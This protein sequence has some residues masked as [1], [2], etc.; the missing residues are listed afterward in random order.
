[1]Q[2]LLAL[3]IKIR[4]NIIMA[5]DVKVLQ[6]VTG[7]KIKCVERCE[8]TFDEIGD[9]DAIAARSQARGSGRGDHT[10]FSPYGGI[11]LVMRERGLNIDPHTLTPAVGLAVRDTIL[12]VLGISTRLKWVNDVLYGDKKVCGILCKCPRRGE[13]LIGVGI[14]FAV[15]RKDLISAE[16]DGVAAT[17]DASEYYATAFTAELIKRI[18]SASLLPFDHNRYN[19][20][21]VT[22]GKDVSFTYNGMQTNGHAEYV[23]RDGSLMVRIGQATV[24]VDC[25]EA[26]IIRTT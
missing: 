2:R 1:M 7:L 19:K 3:Y 4:Y 17:L 6:K 18:H 14:N 16:L 24:A 13:Y 5:I 20:L 8:S 12:N 21:C 26:S 15:N 22:V 11:Y 9:Y 25:G 23:E 10:F